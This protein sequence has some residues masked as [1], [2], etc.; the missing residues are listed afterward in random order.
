MLEVLEEALIDS[1]KILPFLLIVFFIMEFIEHKFSDKGKKLIKKSGKFGPLF[2]GILGG[3]PQCGFSVALTN[4][5]ATKIVSMGTLVAV[6]LSTTDEMI[7]ILISNGVS[8]KEILQL[9]LIQMLIAIVSGFIIDLFTKK[10]KEENITSFCEEEHCHC[11]HD[12][13]IKSSIKHALNIF[14]YILIV[15]LFI[16]GVMYFLGE[17]FIASILLKDNW[18]SP[19][20][21]ATIGLIPNCVSSVMLTELYLSNLISYGSVISGLLMGS[22]VAFLVLFRVNKNL[23]ENITIILITYF[24]SIISGIVIDFIV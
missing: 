12:G 15:T 1:L 10:K 14:A 22:G 19:I 23:K 24:I 18:F 2:G 7:P 11:D 21:A 16:N 13:I 20:I 3:F 8:L 5:F 9:V 17:E 4:L 6:Y